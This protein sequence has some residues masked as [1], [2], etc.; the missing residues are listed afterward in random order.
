MLQEVSDLFLWHFLLDSV[1]TSACVC[2]VILN[3]VLKWYHFYVIYT[4]RLIDP[5]RHHIITL[6]ALTGGQLKPAV[7]QLPYTA[8][9]GAYIINRHF[10]PLLVK[11]LC[12]IITKLI[13]H[14]SWDFQQHTHFVAFQL[15]F[16]HIILAW[17]FSFLLCSETGW[18]EVWHSPVSA[19]KQSTGQASHNR[20]VQP[21]W[22]TATFVKLWDQPRRLSGCG[23]VD[24]QWFRLEGD[25]NIVGGEST[26]DLY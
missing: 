1:E 17:H 5:V 4:K 10:Q 11:A 19:R 7:T 22:K 24:D 25:I 13:K 6:W 2:Q 18:Q 8:R 23:S 16:L 15:C 20:L 21:S 14:S 3:P 9:W 12:F 26:A